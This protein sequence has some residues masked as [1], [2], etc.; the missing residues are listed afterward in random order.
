M[1]QS[2][3]T[4]L[5]WIAASPLWLFKGFTLLLILNADIAEATTFVEDVQQP[6]GFQSLM[7]LI[8]STMMQMLRLL[9]CRIPT[10][11]LFYLTLIR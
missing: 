2:G 1:E 11:D 9:K 3:Q 5:R 7:K 6:M 4:Q 10:C 8:H